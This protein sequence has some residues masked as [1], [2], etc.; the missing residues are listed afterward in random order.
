MEG[1]TF[2]ILKSM[3][4]VQSLTH[5]NGL[6]RY[7][8]KYVGKIDEQN[9][10][11]V[12]SHPHHEGT[13][14]SNATFLKNTKVTSSSILENQVLSR[15]R[16]SFHPKGRLIS[17]MEQIQTMLGFHQVRTDMSFE[18]I[19]TLPL[20]YRAGKEIN[21]N[22]SRS[23]DVNNDDHADGVDTSF[24][25]NNIRKKKGLEEWRQLTSS[26]LIILE[27]ATTT[28]VSID[29]ITKF[30]LRPPELKEVVT[31]VG[32]YYRWFYIK[33]KVLSETIIEKVMTKTLKT[34]CWI[35]S[36]QKQVFLRKKALPELIASIESKFTEMG[37]QCTESFL[38]M[39]HWLKNI[40]ELSIGNKS[41]LNERQLK[42]WNFIEESLLYDDGGKHLTIPVFS[43]V[44]PTLGPRFILHLLLSLGHFETELDLLL[45]PNLR[46][47]LRYAKLI[48]PSNDKEDLQRY[49]YLLQVLFIKEQLIYFPNGSKVISSWIV[50][51]GDLLD[52]VIVN[53]EIPISD[54]PPVLQSRLENAQTCQASLYLQEMKLS[55]LNA[56]Y[57]ELNHVAEYLE[58][59][60][61]DLICDSTM[62]FPVSWNLLQN[63]KRTPFQ[64]VQS[65]KEQKEALAIGVKAIDVYCE[66][67]SQRLFLKSVM[68]T[69]SPGTGKTFLEIC[70]LLYAM[71]KGLH[72]GVTSVMSKRAVQLGGVH[73]HKMFCLPGN[74][75]F[76]LSRLAEIALTTLTSKYSKYYFLQVLDVIFIDEIGQV[77]AELIATLDI[78]LRKLK[79]NDIFFGGILIISTMDHKQLAPIKGRPLLTSPHVL[80]C[81]DAFMLKQSVRANDDKNLSEIQ[82]I[83]RMYFKKYR[84]NETLLPR[85]KSLLSEYCTFVPT[86]HSPLITPDV[87][88]IY[89]KKKPAKLASQEYIQQVKS[90]L[91]VN[92]YVVSKS[93]DVEL[94]YNSHE[95]WQPATDA[96]KA[97]LD[98]QSKTQQEILFFKG[99]QFLFTYNNEG[100]F[101][102]SQIGLLLEVPCQS[103]VSS[104][105]KIP[106]L[107]SPPG[108]KHSL[109]D[110]NIKEEEY[111]NKG[112][113]RT[114][115]GTAPENT[116]SVQGNLKAQRKQYGLKPHVTSTVHASM[117][118]TLC[119]IAIEISST[120]MNFKL[121]DKAQVVVL[122]SRTRY[123]KDIIFVGNKRKTI[124]ALTLLIQLNTQW[125]EY[126]ES[127]LSIICKNS[128]GFVAP[129][130]FDYTS[131]PFRIK[132]VSLP[133]CNTGFCYMLISTKDHSK[134]YIGQTNLLGK[135][136]KQHN[137]GYG[138]VFTD[139]IQYRPWFLFAY[140]CGFSNDKSLMKYFE[141]K[142][143]EKRNYLVSV[144]RKN[145]IMLA[146]CAESV[147]KDIDRHELKLILLFKNS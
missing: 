52:A 78:V 45:K 3:Q 25:C 138:S 95:E 56:I 24:V 8:C 18:L 14:I 141:H 43:Y 106:I 142:W 20:E 28:R 126:M 119:R 63:M 50:I 85:F 91:S 10:V 31:Q 49:S 65:Y 83:S 77:S 114:F 105:K 2:S 143:Q 71:C 125:E 48:G 146:M 116:Y 99:A 53:D 16:S 62:E 100:K 55:M 60:C 128:N 123:A 67:Y 54:M 70:L 29:K 129:K 36:L 58:L 82:D 98:H 57:Q 121:W 59:P 7:V 130:Y 75:K 127:V 15:K 104:F 122:L 81:F 101:S 5:T 144:G 96:T 39:Y 44:K 109:Y 46:E 80:T 30:S 61:K 120:E 66:G 68:I 34:S 42:R 92:A 19:S 17:L 118:D 135:R 108:Y 112:W 69:G 41:E 102:Q 111:L 38:K 86:W 94:T 74:N 133:T 103:D 9:Q 90:H 93:V 47:S 32:M 22:V 147:A 26:E 27:G 137:S 145:P 6:N 79:M 117:G 84:E 97:S 35:D 51:A 76:N 1:Y 136:L 89:G 131:F 12:R 72:C 132:D 88:R 139:D 115:V 40:L 73:I 110:S 37:S 13:L 124:Q 140:V 23:T 64:S 11:L 33:P 4:N 87:H 134:N 113:K 21:S 107:V